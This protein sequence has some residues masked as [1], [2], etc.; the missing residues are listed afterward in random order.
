MKQNV[1][2]L[3]CVIIFTHF[4]PPRGSYSN[5]ACKTTPRYGLKKNPT[6]LK[7]IL[8]LLVIFDHF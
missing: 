8:S 7:P 2:N 4:Q 3:I 6:I 5:P 1:K